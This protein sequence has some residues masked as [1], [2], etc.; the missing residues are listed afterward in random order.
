MRYHILIPTD[1]SEN[2]W[3]AIRYAINLYAQKPCTF[4]LSHAWSFVNLGSRTYIP[5]DYID[6]VKDLAKAQLRAVKERAIVETTN[7]QHEF[8]TIFTTDTLID[9]IT[10]SVK[11]YNIDMVV[12]GTKGATGAKEFL[13]GSNTVTVIKKVRLSPL[14]LVPNN[15]KFATPERI[16]FPTDLNRPYGSEL[17]SIMSL[18]HLHNSAI[19]ILHINAKDNLTDVQHSNVEKLKLSLKDFEHRLNWM[20]NFDTKEAAII[21]FIDKNNIDLLAMINYEHSFFENL[22]NEPVINKLGFHSE[23]PFMVVPRVD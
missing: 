2:A 23:V 18:A 20:P 3:S 19:E 13:F 1:F 11:K 9:S 16:A 12:M 7:A 21:D 6:Q 14:L 15:Y 5:A 17:L 4:Y 22:I 8:K 10:S